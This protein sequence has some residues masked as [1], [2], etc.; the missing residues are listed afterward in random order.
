MKA[1]IDQDLYIGGM[2]TF[3]DGQLDAVIESAEECPGECVFI[4]P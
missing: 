3:P 1:W 2:A 4:E